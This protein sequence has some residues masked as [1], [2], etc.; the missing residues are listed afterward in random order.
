MIKKFKIDSIYLIEGVNI[1][2]SWETSKT[3]FV[4]IHTD[5]WRKGWYKKNNQ[6]Q[7]NLTN[8]LKKVTLFAFGLKG[9]EK[10]EIIIKLNKQKEIIQEKGKLKKIEISSKI[11]DL[12][13]LNNFNSINVLK[14]TKPNKIY[15][16][17]KNINTKI[18]Y[19][20]LNIN[21]NE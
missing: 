14:N 4:K 3:F 19:S 10:R 17:T 16:K 13:S 9:I 15:L 2:I 12:K 21:Y 18:N 5:S 1:N 8:D 11:A 6:I 20:N 7:I